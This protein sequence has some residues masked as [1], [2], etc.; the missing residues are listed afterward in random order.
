VQRG[1]WDL[2]DTASVVSVPKRRSGKKDISHLIPS[3]DTQEKDVLKTS[4]HRRQRQTDQIVV[5][6]AIYSTR[7]FLSVIRTLYVRVLHYIFI[8]IVYIS[9]VR[10]IISISDIVS[11]TIIELFSLSLSISSTLVHGARLTF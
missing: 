5:R 6:V 11:L 3:A 8:T 7:I 9:I 2:R 4:T 10:P 1:R